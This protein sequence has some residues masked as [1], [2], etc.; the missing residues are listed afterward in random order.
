MDNQKFKFKIFCLCTNKLN[1]LFLC[2]CSSPKKPG[3]NKHAAVEIVCNQATPPEAKFMDIQ[4]RVH[5]VGEQDYLG[6]VGS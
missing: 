6:L 1:I 2:S 4:D 3:S 5:M